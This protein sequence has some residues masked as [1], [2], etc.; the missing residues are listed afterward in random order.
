MFLTSCLQKGNWSIPEDQQANTAAI[1]KGL[2]QPLPSRSQAPIIY[3][4]LA[5]VNVIIK[6]SQQPQSSTVTI[7]EQLQLPL[8]TTQ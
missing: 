4:S 6:Q 8:N 5:A 3:D 7:A 1:C 2:P